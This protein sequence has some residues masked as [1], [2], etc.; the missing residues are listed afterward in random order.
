MIIDRL[1]AVPLPI[2]LPIGREEHYRGDLDSS[3]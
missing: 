3:R 2:Q 1:G